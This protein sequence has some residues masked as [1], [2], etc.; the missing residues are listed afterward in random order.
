MQLA[1]YLTDKGLQVYF[2][3]FHHKL[4]M[5]LE[6]KRGWEWIGDRSY[7]GIE[8]SFLFG[9]PFTGIAVGDSAW[10]EGTFTEED[11]KL[12]R[13]IMTMWTN[14]AKDG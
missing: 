13:N 5:N 6:S 9:S 11:R 12:C 1:K 8:L 2:Y 7:H 3:Q 4:P 10:Y 14:F